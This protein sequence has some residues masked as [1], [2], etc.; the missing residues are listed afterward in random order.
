M[1]TDVERTQKLEEYTNLAGK[2]EC[3]VEAVS[4]NDPNGLIHLSIEEAL[5]LVDAINELA[6]ETRIQFQDAEEFCKK[7]ED[8]GRILGEEFI[9]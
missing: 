4:E 6:E 3:L 9:S 7:L 8:I 1:M 5:N 2:L